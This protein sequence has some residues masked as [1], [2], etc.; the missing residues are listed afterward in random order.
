MKNPELMMYRA[1]IG[2]ILADAGINRETI[3][4]MVQATIDEKVSRQTPPIIER[5][6]ANMANKNE[7]R[8]A[9]RDATRS[10]IERAV[11]KLDIAIN[12]PLTSCTDNELI[13]EC[14]RRGFTIQIT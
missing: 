4:D 5:N 8:T 7:F 9:V 10:E 11:G 13:R 3:K 1:A 6:I 12:L 2:Q 14:A